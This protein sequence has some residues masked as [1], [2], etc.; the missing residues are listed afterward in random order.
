MYLWCTC[1]VLVC[2]CVY[3]YDLLAV[4]MFNEQWHKIQYSSTYD[5]V[6]LFLDCI[7]VA[8]KQTSMPGPIDVNGEILIGRKPNGKSAEVGPQI[9]STMSRRSFI[10]YLC[11]P[12]IR[13]SLSIQLQFS[14]FYRERSLDPILR[15]SD[16]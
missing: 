5:S 4:Q 9:R 13:N 10:R 12:I 15:R 6:N 3:M 2:T 16:S 11:A 7:Q 8:S 1:D 14:P